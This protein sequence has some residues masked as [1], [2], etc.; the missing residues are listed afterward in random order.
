M[1]LPTSSRVSDVYTTNGNQKDF[2]FGFRVFYDPENG[3][4]GLEVR[5][6]TADGYEVIPKSDYLV[7]PVE[8]NSA[9]VVRF[10]IA[11]P[12]GQQIYI[13][14][15]TPTIQQ[16]V[17]TNF[18]RYSAESIETQF[19]FITAI[20]QEWLSAL[21]EETRQ[22]IAAD[23]ILTQYV[24]QRID[25]FV[26]QVNQNFDDKSQEIED[27]I[28]TI[29][30]SFTQ[31]LRDE[32]E[33]F[34]V[35]GMQDAIEQT[36]AESKAEIDDAVA[37][38]NAAALAAAITGKLYDT[39][40][41]GVHPVTGVGNGAYYNVRST[42]DDSY[43]LEYQ[44]IGGVPTPSGKS[45]PSSQAVERLEEGYAIKKYLIDNGV[46]E[47]EL[48]VDYEF[49]MQ[50]LA[51]I[52]SDKGLGASFVVDASGK[53]Q[54]QINDI[55]LSATKIYTIKEL[56]ISNE[57][58]AIGNTSF[59]NC[60]LD[61]G[62]FDLTLSNNLTL[63]LNNVLVKGLKLKPSTY[64]HL[65]FTGANY[66]FTGNDFSGVD[67]PS[68]YF[69]KSDVE[70]NLFI[71][72]ELQGRNYHFYG[73]K[74]SEYVSRQ[75][76][77]IKNSEGFYIYN[78]EVRNCWSY[79]RI[80]HPQGTFD[81]YGDGIHVTFSKDGYV[82]NNIVVNSLNNPIG[83]CGVVVEF[84][85][86]N[87]WVEKNIVC[88]YDR[89]IHVELC[90]DNVYA[91]NNVVFGCNTPLIAWNCNTAKVE[92]FKNTASTI[93]IDKNNPAHDTILGYGIRSIIEVLGGYVAGYSNNG[94]VKFTENVFITSDG[95]NTDSL[96]FIEN[97]FDVK[98]KGNEHI[99]LGTVYP[100]ITLAAD[101]LPR[102]FH[103]N[104]IG[105]KFKDANLSLAHVDFIDIEDNEFNLLSLYIKTG[106]NVFGSIDDR[107]IVDNRFT[108]GNAE[109]G[110]LWAGTGGCIIEDN[111]I[112]LKSFDYLMSA[113]S[114]NHVQNNLFIR[115]SLNDFDIKLLL[116]SN[117]FSQGGNPVACTGDN[118]TFKDEV[119][120]YN[121]VM[122]G[123]GVVKANTHSRHASMTRPPSYV[124]GATIYDGT[125]NKP[126]FCKQRGYQTGN[127]WQASTSYSLYTTIVS[128][129]VVYQCI[130]AGVSAAVVPAL[131]A[132]EGDTTLDAT[133][134]WCS[135]GSS[136][137]W[138]DATGIAV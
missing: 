67:A 110:V 30:P 21:G 88:G 127:A 56:L 12:A 41:A 72:V 44:N 92:F 94:N 25:A 1:T 19:D 126:I 48:A 64:T 71:A 61:F 87:V 9:G 104:F 134:I 122:S 14:G 115:K 34:A 50:R 107:R 93:G 101:N 133:V 26:Q 32:I 69:N 2:S 78:N 62:N 63:N 11:P 43:L 76:L 123:S 59:E 117:R 13:A 46:D 90:E 35:A 15:K 36:L 97:A 102:K 45:Y 10:N 103:A 74:I 47:S 124:S 100:S 136:A 66:I 129:G 82:Q 31:T 4:Y 125:L 80:H 96:I 39:P 60:I 3:G 135:R 68:D 116:A 24:V 108:T 113:E 84:E 105:N 118:N 17:L 89:G 99:K 128:G 70:L 54:Q 52:A 73:N 38:A 85:C 22:R 27:Y 8:D 119:L 5:R 130:R 106:A 86:E 109:G 114:Q 138:V 132:A 23:N 28:A 51:Q 29:M 20:I 112:T 81:N 77:L 131:S 53:N 83:R 6:Q 7:L 75:A 58:S 91:N 37:R 49:L 16:L 95:T 57:L 55:L 65:I 79:N 42:D 98:F 18:G 111:T 121:F 137:I 120:K 33:A 40:E